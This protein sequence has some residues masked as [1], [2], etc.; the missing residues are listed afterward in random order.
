VAAKVYGWLE[1]I[2]VVPECEKCADISTR[3]AA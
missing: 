1:R 2:G 3:L